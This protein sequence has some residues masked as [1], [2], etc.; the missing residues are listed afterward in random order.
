MFILLLLLS[1]DLYSQRDKIEI[2]GII[3]DEESGQNIPFVHVFIKNLNTGTTTDENG[4]FSIR[5]PF[6]DSIEIQLFHTAYEQKIIFIK[7]PNVYNTKVYLKP[8]IYETDE[9]KVQG[10]NSSITKEIIPGKLQLQQKDILLTPTLLGEP[11]LIRTLKLL[12]GIQSVNEGNSGIYVRGGSPG[13]NYITFDEIELMNPSHLMGIYSVFNPFLVDH[14]DF[15]KGNA[16]IQFS[17]RLASSIIVKTFNHKTDSTNWYG[18]IGNL[19]SNISYQGKSKNQKWYTNIGLRRSYLEGI[20]WVADK[21]ITDQNNYF[22]KNHFAFYDFNGKIKYSTPKSTITLAWYKGRDDFDYSNSERIIQMNNKWGNEGASLSWN[23][24]CNSG[25]SIHNSLSYSKYFSSLHI[26]FAEQDL[27]FDT[28]YQHMKHKIEFST[29]KKSHLLRF[30]I[31]S[32]YRNTSPQNLD[33]D[34]NTST[35]TTFYTYKHF[36]SKLFMSDEYKLT[37]NIKLYVGGSVQYYKTLDINHSSTENP[38]ESSE[39]NYTDLLANLVFT[40]N[41]K[42]SPTS[43]I[44][45]SFSHTEQ[46]I[47]LASVASIPLP[48]DI[49]MP[50]TE[51]LPQEKGEQYTLG[52]FGEKHNGSIQYGLEAYAKHLHNQLVYNVNYQSTETSSFESNFFHGEARAYG[53]E[54][55]LKKTSQKFNTNIS[56]TLGWAQ[57]RFNDINNGIWHDAKYD[58]RHDLNILCNYILNKKIDF[59]LVFIFATGNKTTLPVGRYW[60]MGDIANVYE[61]INN[62][63]MPPYHRLDLSLNYHLK[64]NTFK[65]SVLNFSII[66]VLNH[67]NPYFIYFH[68]EKGDESYDIDIQAH[69]V[70]LFPIMPSVSWKFKF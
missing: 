2:T 68:I 18:N 21:L 7:P 59:G 28:N 64:S 23:Y 63:R 22:T 37:N 35:G 46:D 29:E 4:K 44:K 10:K 19:S 13:Q 27:N 39:L 24:I 38:D 40:F 56:Y 47:H 57:Q 32:T 49:W 54:V 69:Q 53:V 20:Q 51:S 11:D 50:A 5:I 41:Y 66:N 70:A 30:G 33:L 1:I 8:K 12:P 3:S 52:L 43:S 62:F 42:L 61:G 45:G 17:S 9:I 67:A 48:S 16:P 58:R 14:V 31:H 6:S 65:E 60:M 55:F 15:Y 25:L 36:T 34:L 26:F